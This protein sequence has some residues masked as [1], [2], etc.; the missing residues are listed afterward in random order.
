MLLTDVVMPGIVSKAF[1]RQVQELRPGIQVLF[2]SGYER[3]PD[4]PEGWPEAG[5][6]L[7]AKPFSRS[8]LLAMVA[9]MLAVDVNAR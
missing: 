9:K 7:L 6:P 1:V 2:M 8:A 5:I 3:P 4:A